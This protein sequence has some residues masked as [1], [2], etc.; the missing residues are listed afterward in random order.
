MAIKTA[1]DLGRRICEIRRGQKKKQAEV[2]K[3][4]GISQAQ[5]SKIERG[6]HSL[7]FEKLVE[8]SDYFGVTPNDILNCQPRK[9]EVDKVLEIY[10]ELEQTAHYWYDGRAM[11]LAEAMGRSIEI[12][13]FDGLLRKR[14]EGIVLNEYEID[15][16]LYRISSPRLVRELEASG[17]AKYIGR[18]LTELINNSHL[19]GN[20]SFYLRFRTPIDFSIFSGEASVHVNTLEATLRVTYQ[21]KAPFRVGDKVEEN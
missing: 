7:S 11:S 4:V 9:T 2:A 18:F 16:F 14:L 15:E 20:R 12:T 21:E 5:Y 19:A 3:V 1:E 10:K 6:I 13:K 8:I 17:E